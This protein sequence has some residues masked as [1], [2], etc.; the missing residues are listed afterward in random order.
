MFTI[1]DFPADPAIVYLEHYHASA[2]LNGLDAIAPYRKLVK[3][4]LGKALT[5]DASQALLREVPR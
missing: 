5:E 1:Y 4:L 2:F 3:L